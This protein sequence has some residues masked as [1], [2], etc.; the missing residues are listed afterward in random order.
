MKSRNQKRATSAKMLGV[1]AMQFRGTRD[2]VDRAGIAERYSQVIDDLIAGQKWT[3]M[4]ALE[5]Q[6][7]DEWMPGA[8]FKY[9]NLRPPRIQASRTGT[10]G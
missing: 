8:F 9:W 2:E 6:L 3:T 4:P 1:L 5:D 10:D 7:P